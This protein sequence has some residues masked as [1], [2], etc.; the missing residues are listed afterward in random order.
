MASSLLLTTRCIG[1]SGFR[2]HFPCNPEVDVVIT[3]VQR[4]FPLTPT[5]KKTTARLSTYHPNGDYSRVSPSELV[6]GV[7]VHEPS[8]LTKKQD[9]EPYTT[10]SKVKLRRNSRPNNAGPS[11]PRYPAT[12]ILARKILRDYWGYP[13]FRLEQEAVISRLIAGGSASA[14]FPTGSGKSL[15]YQVPALAFDQLDKEAKGNPPGLTLVISPLIALMKVRLA[16]L[17]RSVVQRC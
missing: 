12:S 9:Y 16:V 15:L 2:S 7:G 14:V 3:K 6:E 11:S 5:L 13:G 1:K 17:P 10:L 4:R 8:C